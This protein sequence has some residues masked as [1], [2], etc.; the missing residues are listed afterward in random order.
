MVF[1]YYTWE[2]FV[3][4]GPWVNRSIIEFLRNQAN[5]GKQ[6]YVNLEEGWHGRGLSFVSDS[7]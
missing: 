3:E 4:N 5:A 2:D 6:C 7:P 1:A